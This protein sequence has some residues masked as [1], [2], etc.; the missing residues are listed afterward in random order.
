MNQHSLIKLLA[1]TAAVVGLAFWVNTAR[2]P[3]TSAS[4]GGGL[5][6][7]GMKDKINQVDQLRVFGAGNQVLVTLKRQDNRWT[8]GERAGYAADIEKVREYLLRLADARLIEAKTANAALYAKLGVEDVKAPDAKG[9]RVEIDG[10]D[11]PVRLV[12]GSF[13][14]QGGGGTFVRRDAEPQSWLAQGTLIPEKQP[15]NWLDKALADIPSSR[16]QRVEIGR[17]GKLLVAHKEHPSDANFQIDGVPKGR[18]LNSAFEGNG[19]AAV[20][21]G[22]R[23]ED[24]RKADSAAETT[25]PAL[26]AHYVSF[27]G[28]VIDATSQIEGDKTWVRFAAHYDPVAAEAHVKREQ[29]Q[30][31]ADHAAASK[32]H[33]DQLAA[34]PAA[35][36][37]APAQPAAE[38][39]PAPV[40]PLAVTDPVKDRMQRLA[41]I[42]E[43]VAK[44]NARFAGWSFQLPP[45]TYSNMSRRMDDLLKPERVES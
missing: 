29:T 39:P 32:A 12:V 23:F 5:L 37:K 18:E 17:D 34:T 28:L 30:A 19:L 15:G 8:V 33:A 26:T 10:L 36:A 31:Q 35:D 13:N 4:A 7:P 25:T 45:Y 27:D 16:I 44:L 42:E 21:A 11:K 41:A 14:G 2:S 38:P 6:V 20:L 22:L 9:N 3:E 40:A 43:E 1:A 24:V